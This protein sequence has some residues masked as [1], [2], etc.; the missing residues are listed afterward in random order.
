MNKL[1]LQLLLGSLLAISIIN[2]F[3]SVNEK[4]DELALGTETV[5][6][7]AKDKNEKSIHLTKINDLEENDFMKSYSENG[8]NEVCFFI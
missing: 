3:F 4:F 7:M 1:L 2:I 6:Y 5:T 8:N